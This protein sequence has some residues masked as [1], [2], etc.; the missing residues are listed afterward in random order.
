[1]KS[2]A[3]NADMPIPAELE[4]KIRAHLRKH[5]GKS[6]LLFTN[7]NGRPLCV[8]KLREKLLHQLLDSPGI[9][10]AGFHSLRHGA[11]SVAYVQLSP[12]CK[13]KCATVTRV[14]R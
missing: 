6:E 3:S 10:F 9:P 2:K 4:V 5:D 1:V 12:Q 13:S 14:P 7:R 8:D 11:A